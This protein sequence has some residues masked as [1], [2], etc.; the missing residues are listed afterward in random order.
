M[1][2][3]IFWFSLALISSSDCWVFLAKQE[4]PL[5][6]R[7]SPVSSSEE[8][9]SRKSLTGT[10]SHWKYLPHDRCKTHLFFEFCSIWIALY[11]HK[12]SLW[13]MSDSTLFQSA[14]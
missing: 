2:W 10:R 11:G 3:P 13:I 5:S 12:P 4:K 6:T 14:L 7:Q 9:D 8:S 1:S